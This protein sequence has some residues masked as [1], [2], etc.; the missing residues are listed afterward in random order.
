MLFQGELVTE[1]ADDRT[2][3]YLWAFGRLGDNR[4]VVF[5]VALGDQFDPALGDFA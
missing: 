4:C 5:L 1:D 3:D 2:G